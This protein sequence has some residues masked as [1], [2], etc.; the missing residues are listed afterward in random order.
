[1]KE[2]VRFIEPIELYNLLNQVSLGV[3]CITNECYLLLFDSRKLEEYVESHIIRATHVKYDE[4]LGFIFPNHIDYSCVENIVVM[5]NRASS[6]KDVTSSA[7]IC[8]QLLWNM[9]SKYPIQIAKGGF[10][11]FSALYPFLRTQ[12]ILYTQKE[13][14]M[15]KM[16]PVEVEAGFL[17][18]GI[19]SH[20]SDKD[21]AKHL[22]IKAH[23]NLTLKDDPLFKIGDVIVGKNKEMVPQV[24]NLNI[25]DNID[26]DILPHF[27]TV[28]SFID[29]HRKNDGK[30]VLIYSDLGIGRCASIVLAYL[31]N[32]KKISLKEALTHLNSCHRYVCP[33]RSFVSSLLQ[34]EN[35]VLGQV[36]TKRTDLGFLSYE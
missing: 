19:Y 5:D 7:V 14:A 13:I 16:Y 26:A 32:K 18:M 3:P 24:V 23:I 29:Q 36:L 2:K 4:K 15:I 11:D 22:K 6:I 12:K 10:E 27:S 17:Y 35:T 20:A 30:A 8:A 21:I 1:M 28:C 31:I 33:N 34:W 9:G 25:E